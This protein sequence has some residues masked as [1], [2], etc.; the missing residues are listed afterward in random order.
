MAPRRWLT[1][2]SLTSADQQHAWAVLRTTCADNGVILPVTYPGAPSPTGG[3]SRSTTATMTQ[4]S[5]VPDATATGI[6]NSIKL[7]TSFG[8][9]TRLVKI[10]LLLL[11]GG[12][13]SIKTLRHNSPEI[14]T[15]QPS[16]VLTQPPVV[17]TQPSVTSNT[18]F[19][20]AF[21]SRSV[22][23][24]SIR[25]SSISSHSVLSVANSSSPSSSTSASSKSAAAASPPSSS[26]LST[27][28]KIGIGVGVP[29]GVICIAGLAF[30]FGRYGRKHMTSRAGHGGRGGGSKQSILKRMGGGGAGGGGMDE[31]AELDAPENSAGN[32]ELHGDSFP[33]YSP[34]LDGNSHPVLVRRE[35]E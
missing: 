6:T 20:S 21:S 3:S 34:E 10:L 33:P 22:S 13:G 16:V 7:S 2:D 24:I 29:L 9:I 5:R 32:A 25:P 27:F 8:S 35:L 18:A 30:Y 26:G 17:T 31:K 11:H 4:T 28:A 15:G 1:G 12:I 19:P 14:V 23:S